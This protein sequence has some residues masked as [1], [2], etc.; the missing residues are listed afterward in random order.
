MHPVGP[1][2]MV[3]SFYGPFLESCIFRFNCW[4]PYSAYACY[5]LSPTWC[6]TKKSNA[7]DIQSRI[8]YKK[9]DCVSSFLYKFFLVQKSC[10]KYSTALFDTRNLQT[11][12]QNWAMW[13]ANL[14]IDFWWLVVLLFALFAIVF[15]W[16]VCFLYKKLASKSDASFLGVYLQPFRHSKRGLSKSEMVCL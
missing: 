5:N 7:S 6:V 13:L 15:L 10:I 12:D 8:L 1:V 14:F 3:Q 16:L 4:Q 11:C 2:R 9:L